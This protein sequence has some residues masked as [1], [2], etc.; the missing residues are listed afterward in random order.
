M[1]ILEIIVLLIAILMYFI[2]TFVAMVRGH[3]Q[4]GALVVMN[5]IFGWTILGWGA[6]VVWSFWR[7]K[8]ANG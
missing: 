7:F 2:P 5:I 6:A 3:A 8:G 1:T 4:L